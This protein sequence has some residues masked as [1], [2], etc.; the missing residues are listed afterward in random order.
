M[1]GVRILAAAL[2]AVSALG[3]AGAPGATEAVSPVASVSGL[4]AAVAPASDLPIPPVPPMPAIPELPGLGNPP[5]PD[6]DPFYRPPDRLGSYR[7]GALLRSRSVTVLG[8]TSLASVK[9]YQLLYR[10][11]DAT[12]HPVATVTTLMLP[13][14]PAPGPRKLVS[15]HTAED[16]LT[17]R[18]APSYTLRTGGG[19]TQS[20][21]SALITPLLAHGWDVV[22]PDYQGP[23][24]EWAV[25]AMAGHAALDSVRAAEQFRPAGLDGHRTPVGMMGYSGDSI[26]TAWANS[27]AEDYA[28]ELNLVGVA[29]GGI[30]ADVKQSLP[31]IDG[32]PFFGAIAVTIAFDR[33]YPSLELDS[34]L[35]E[36]GKD[37][38]E[39][40][41]HDAYGCAG[42]I[43]AAPF[44]RL[45]QYTRYR[46]TSA[47]LDVPRVRRTMDRISLLG[48]AR[49]KAP[50]YFYNAIHDELI[51]IS[52]VDDLVK[53]N[54]ADGATIQY[55][56]D[57]VGGHI[58]GAGAYAA[59][60][61]NYLA[62]RFA[63]R[64]APNTCRDRR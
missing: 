64:H 57:P 49:Q 55:V 32:S 13:T 37:F 27:M 8:L 59:P 20:V 51:V 53:E 29:A 24:S 28:P 39:Q 63:G 30:P 52:Q 54:C 21:E 12:G 4:G 45:D 7:P 50:A 60:A 35:T 40:A 25:G 23:R 36:R 3:C 56:R 34:L 10:T 22:V 16:S 58:T 17:T 18:C 61:I 43:T 38:A 2:L 47:L 31:T 33:A 15:Y 44:G 48:R 6:E 14:L 5:V 42:A 11:T 1:A 9:A 41:A 19:T 46:D 26:P 62:D